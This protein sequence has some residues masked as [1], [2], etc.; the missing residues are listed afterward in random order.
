MKFP[1]EWKN[2]PNVPN[3]QSVL[4]GMNSGMNGM[5]FTVFTSR[6]ISHKNL[7]PFELFG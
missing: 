4:S 5:V 3:H 7:N 1:T 2:D 6:L